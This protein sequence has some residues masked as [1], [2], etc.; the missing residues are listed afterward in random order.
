M[1][2][3]PGVLELAKMAVDRA[4]RGRGYGE[5]LMRAAIAHARRAGARK[6]TLVSYT[7]LAPA[8]AHY[9]TCGF[10]EV[11]IEPGIEYTRADIQM[12]LELDGP[13]PG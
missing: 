8:I 11:P 3:A 10:V 7:R 5:L 6:V 2:H 12:E 9:R 4:A 1:P 13:A